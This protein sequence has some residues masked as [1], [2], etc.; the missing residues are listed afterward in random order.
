MRNFIK[1]NNVLLMMLAFLLILDT[2]AS[3]QI[4]TDHDSVYVARIVDFEKKPRSNG[5]DTE[6]GSLVVFPQPTIATDG[7]VRLE[8]T[9]AS[10][11]SRLCSVRLFDVQGRFVC[12]IFEGELEKGESLEL[13][14]SGKGGEA[15]VPGVYFVSAELGGRE[16][17]TRKIVLLR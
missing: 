17:F 3:G 5:D 2:C 10:S 15:V 12:T 14:I 7:K 8:V 16:T 9:G 4:V 6:E 11:L 13:G 1:M